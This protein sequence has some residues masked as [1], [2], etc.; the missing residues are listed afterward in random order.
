M[1][2][3]RALYLRRKPSR[4]IVISEVVNWSGWLEDGYARSWQLPSGT[5]GVEFTAS[6]DGG[7]VEISGSDCFKTRAMLSYRRQCEISYP[8]QIVVTN[9]TVFATGKAISVALRVVRM[10]KQ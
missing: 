1:S 7:T 4:A 2:F 5:Y 3:R 10:Q 6:G 9:P 8:G